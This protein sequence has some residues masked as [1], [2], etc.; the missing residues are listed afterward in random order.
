[1]RDFKID[2]KG[3]TQLYKNPI[4]EKLTRTNFL[5]PV[6]LYYLIS[7]FCISYLAIYRPEVKLVAYSWLFLIGLILF[8]LVEYLIHRFVF[9]FNAETEK[10]QQLQYNIHGVHHEY[11]RDKDRLVM[12]PVLSIFLASFFF[13]LF[14]Y[15]IG[16]YGVILFAGFAA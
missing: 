6:I 11:P 16:I 5:F 14:R 13:V 8:T 3:T 7:A 10:E 12:P 15:T 9:H 4:L 1:M 2:N